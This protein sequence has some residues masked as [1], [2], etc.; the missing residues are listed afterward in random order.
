MLSSVRLQESGS[1]GIVH[2]ALAAGLPVAALC[3]G[4][5]VPEDIAPASA[6]AILEVLMP[7]KSGHK[8]QDRS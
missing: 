8:A 2:A 3:F 5:R 6:E 1:A 7:S 4:Q